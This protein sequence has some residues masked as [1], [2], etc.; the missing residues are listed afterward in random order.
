MPDDIYS[1]KIIKGL[2]KEI[3][4]QL[5]KGGGMNKQRISGSFL[6]A[7]M[8]TLLAACGGGGGSS[9]PSYNMDASGGTVTS[10]DGRASVIVPAGAVSNPLTLSIEPVS[11]MQGN[12]GTAYDFN[13]D[14]LSFALPVTITIQYDDA[15]VGQNVDENDLMLAMWTGTNWS[16]VLGSG[17]DPVSNI[18]SGETTHFSTYGIV[19]FQVLTNTLP[20]VADFSFS[21][22][23]GATYSGMLS[24]S[25]ADN[26]RL[27]Y[28]FVNSGS[29]GTATIT[30]ATTGD[31][32]YTANAGATG[33]DTLTYVA[34]DGS[35]DSNL[36]TVTVFFSTLPAGHL[37][38]VTKADWGS[39]V[40]ALASPASS[41]PPL[42]CGADCYTYLADGTQAVLTGVPT[43]GSLGVIWEGCDLV[44]G[45]QCTVNMTSDRYITA[46]FISVV[47]AGLPQ[48]DNNGKYALRWTCVNPTICNG[49][50]RIQE[51]NDEHFNTYTEYSYTDPTGYTPTLGARGFS[52]KADGV[53][54]YR[55]SPLTTVNWSQPVCVV[56]DRLERDSVGFNGG[57]ANGNSYGVYIAPYGHAVVFS[58]EA[59]NLV[60]G[61]TEGFRDVFFRDTDGGSFYRV[62]FSA[63]DPG[64]GGNG[65]SYNAVMTP[66]KRYI[67]FL[68]HASNLVDN[69]TNNCADYF[70]YDHTTRKI[71]RVS[72]N[73]F[74][75][76][77]DGG[78]FSAGLDMT[79]NGRYVVF[80]TTSDLDGGTDDPNFAADVYIR[81]RAYGYTFNLS[82]GLNNTVTSSDAFNP[83]I[84]SSMG[85]YIAY[86]ST[87]NNLVANDTNN[88]SDIFLYDMQTATI[89]RVSTNASGVQANGAS[90]N[91]S[92]T[93][94]GRYVAFDSFATNLVPGDTN[95]QRDVFV[96]DVVNGFIWRVSE[97]ETMVSGSPVI[98][99][100]NGSSYYP[101]ISAQGY[102]IAFQSQ[103]TNLR[104]SDTNNN[105][106]VYIKYMPTATLT[107]P[108]AFVNRVNGTAIDANNFSGGPAISADGMYVGFMSMAD[109][110]IR[111]SSIIDAA[112]YNDTNGGSDVFTYS[113]KN[114]SFAPP[115]ENADND[116]DGLTNIYELTVSFT[117]PFNAD[118]DGDGVSDKAEVDAGTD[119]LDPI[120][121]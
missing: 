48:N 47:Q 30:N 24:G 111:Y 114:S 74:G 32:T 90:Q 46:T 42:N 99:Q 75:D 93:A 104:T 55:V 59:T 66:D 62:S 31:F 101:R 117:L 92:I 76:S 118:T 10:T 119:P 49:T 57:Q 100:G 77:P 54:C 44:N 19:P 7:A 8:I 88:A 63:A 115:A 72:I 52:D 13:P 38:Q 26:N 43:A 11:G 73:N 37:L 41:D 78:S 33:T 29:Q 82:K 39:G 35:G 80:S 58:S 70:V 51:A 61:D 9:A 60:S 4:Y 105:D 112:A 36:G 20:V 106:D 120:S 5:E 1:A 95:G 12:V 16:Q 84:A 94:D 22:Q 56:V 2:K 17:S 68:S 91:P 87:A 25:D 3:S 45:A 69:D 34:N 85:R 23:A 97:T 27:T 21:V 110:L 71:E 108:L 103:A 83:V 40:V 113:L 67:A 28:R 50:Y 121:N 14:G 98:V 79:W 6:I 65:D 107:G 53:Y 86:Q 109:N 15:D 81:D 89:K 64:V 96:K 18:V 102:R 116:G